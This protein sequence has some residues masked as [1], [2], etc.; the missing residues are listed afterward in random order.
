MR[1]G[2]RS[3]FSNQKSAVRRDLMLYPSESNRQSLCQEKFS[4]QHEQGAQANISD[5]SDMRTNFVTAAMV[6]AFSLA[7]ACN[8]KKRLCNPNHRDIKLGNM[9]MA[10][11]TSALRRLLLARLLEATAMVLASPT[12]S[13][14]LI[15]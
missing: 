4:I 10:A 6:P 15:R 14:R 8:C 11:I 9:P 5:C 2:Y 1:C 7:S 12:V 13:W 3:S